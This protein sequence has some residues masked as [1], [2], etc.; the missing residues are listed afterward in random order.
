MRGLLEAMSL[1][2]AGFVSAFTPRPGLRSLRA[3]LL[4]LRFTDLRFTT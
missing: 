3:R 2:C 4:D 1:A